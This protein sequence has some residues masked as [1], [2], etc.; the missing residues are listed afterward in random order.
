M[1]APVEELFAGF[2]PL[3]LASL[4]ARAAL[5]RRLDNKYVVPVSRLEE[6]GEKLRGDHD[7][8]EIDGTRV[9][10]YESNY[11]DTPGLDCF[12]DH[13]DERTP[14]FKVR[15]RYYVTTAECFFEVKVKREGDETVKRHLGYEV[16]D[17]RT[18]RGP[19]R[20]LLAATLAECSIPSPRDELGLSIVTRFRRA[21]LAAR[22]EPER[23]TI[24]FGVE[25]EAAGGQTAAIDRAHAIV[26]TKTPDG[27]GPCDRLL[28][29]AGIEAVALSKYR[30][31]VGLLVAPGDDPNYARDVKALFSVGSPR[32]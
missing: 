21:T 20:E 8:L 32:A 15:T 17:R 6:I 26:E 25:L 2:R 12:R 13:V 29:R 31:G 14:R 19:A 30:V 16:D 10:E 18:I 5:Q 4:D 3:S 28:A 22:D 1:D 11:F 23:V 27:D 9:F 7:V 24:D